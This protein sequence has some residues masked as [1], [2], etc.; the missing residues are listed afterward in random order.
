AAVY[1]AELW[2]PTTE[3]WQTIAAMQVPRLYH[4]TALLLPD[5]RVVVAGSGDS[6]GGPDQT[7]AQFYVPPYLFKGTR[8][9]MA[10]VPSVIPYGTA[11]AVGLTD[12]S[13]IASVAL[14]RQGAVTHQF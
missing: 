3:T 9:A 12:A 5:G 8:P 10:S 14:V 1:E 7:T 4:S 11:F 2:S 6:F 13:P